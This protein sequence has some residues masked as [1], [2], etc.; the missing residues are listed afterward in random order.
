MS[1]L[2]KIVLAAMLS[3]CSGG[4]GISTVPAAGGSWLSDSVVQSRGVTVSDFKRVAAWGSKGALAVVQCPQGYKVVAGGS[5]TVRS[6]TARLFRPS[7]PTSTKNVRA[8]F[9][10][11]CSTAE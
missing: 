10:I 5:S 1:V 2:K 7:R 9:R 4:H 6:V 8:F 11:F 3:A